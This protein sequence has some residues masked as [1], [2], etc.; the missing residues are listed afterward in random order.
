[1]EHFLFR[2]TDVADG[3]TAD[4]PAIARV[5]GNWDA[6]QGYLEASAP[7]SHT[8][9]LASTDGRVETDPR[10]LSETGKKAGTVAGLREAREL[11]D[12]GRVEEA[13]AACRA[14]LA[15]GQPSAGLLSLLGIIHQTLL[16][17]EKAAEFFEKRCTCPRTM[18]KP[19]CT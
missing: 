13:L 16:D 17:V 6:D 1:M 10:P 5:S 9:S 2:R 19:Y 18:R 15:L 4:A 8:P 7:A 14:Q 12:A 3:R 11:A